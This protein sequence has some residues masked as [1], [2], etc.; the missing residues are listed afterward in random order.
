MES[1]IGVGKGRQTNYHLSLKHQPKK[2]T[3][4]KIIILGLVCVISS[5]AILTDAQ[6]EAK[7]LD[8]NKLE[9]VQDEIV[10]KFQGDDN[11]F[12]VIKVQKGKVEEKVKEY[13]NKANVVYAEPNYILYALETPNDTYYGN[14]WALN[15][16][17]WEQAWTDFS[18]APFTETI[19][20][21]LDT[22]VSKNHTDLN[23]KLI[24]GWNFIDN[25]DNTD[26]VYG[27]GTHVAGIAGAETNNS[28]GI[29]G[30]AFPNNTQIMPVKVLN[31]YGSSV[32][33]SVADGIYY[34]ANNGAQV[35]NLSL[36]G[37]YP[38]QA[39]EDAVNYAW[40]QGVL[41]AAAAGNDG[42]RTFSYPASYPN[43]MS[44]AATDSADKRARFSNFNNEI[45]IS[46]PG[47]NV[48]S[49][50]LNNWY[51]YGSG[52]S[53]SCP[54]IA[55]L[56][57]LLFAQN[58]SRSNADIRAII[59]QT[60]DD[61]GA[62]GW[63]RYYGWGRINVYK[64]LTYTSPIDNDNDGYNSDNDCDDNNPLINPGADE[65]CD[66][67][68]DNDCDGLTDAEDPDCQQSGCVN[69]GRYCNCNNKCDKFENSEICPWDCAF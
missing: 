55:G 47:V 28:T 62:A 31:D 39:M 56:A 5:V 52:T 6:L 53:M 41:I 14:Q 45:D 50:Y 11:P 10:V 42:S 16:T 17:D 38:S 54:H 21:I 19:I 15:N 51:G 69:K 27:H 1:L 30:I 26:D 24:P 34:A 44:V 63:D 59:E 22:G 68:T 32:S 46:A 18:A 61:L 7:D 25:N 64:A 12:R 36:G 2:M 57:G 58:N 40:E 43:V 33:T 23:D 8:K 20:A 9:Y 35:I 48:L 37:K 4:T 66:D 65:I 67:G 49:T 29:A 60:A 3:K 13:K